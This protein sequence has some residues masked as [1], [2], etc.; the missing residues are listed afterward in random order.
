MSSTSNPFIPVQLP[1]RLAAATPPW[2][3]R[4]QPSLISSGDGGAAGASGAGGGGVGDGS[5]GSR[6]A[7]PWDRSAGAISAAARDVGASTAVAMTAAAEADRAEAF[8]GP[9]LDRENAAA[10]EAAEEAEETEDDEEVGR[11]KPVSR[12]R[13]LHHVAAATAAAEADR[14]AGGVFVRPVR[15]KLHPRVSGRFPAA[16]TASTAAAILDTAP[17]KRM[18]QVLATFETRASAAFAAGG[19]GGGCVGHGGDGASSSGAV[20]G[21]SFEQVAGHPLLRGHYNVWGPWWAVEL[22]SGAH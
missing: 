11:S 15:R 5:G 19:H 18:H 2:R 9:G 8:Q 20:E 21:F 10:E 16:F 22:M 12:S 1:G 4:R 17:M 13:A 7:G 3:A 6:V 14:A